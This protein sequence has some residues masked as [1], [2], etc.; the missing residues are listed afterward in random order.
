MANWGCLQKQFHSS[1]ADL[2]K[3]CLLFH[4]TVIFHG[5]VILINVYCKLNFTSMHAITSIHMAYPTTLKFMVKLGNLWL[6]VPLE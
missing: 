4:A 6:S 2:D 3:G 5:L 1:S